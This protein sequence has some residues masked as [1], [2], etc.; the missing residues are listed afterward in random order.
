MWCAVCI[1]FHCSVP[2]GTDSKDRDIFYFPMFYNDPRLY[3][4]SKNKRGRPFRLRVLCDTVEG[5]EGQYAMF[6]KSR[7]KADKEIFAS[8]EEVMQHYR[9]QR[10]RLAKEAEK[11]KKL[12]AMAQL[13]RRL[14]GR[15]RRKRIEEER[16]ASTQ[17]SAAVG[18]ASGAPHLSTPQLSKCVSATVVD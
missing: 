15:L 7:R 4:M 16:E 1:C 9:D 14:S 17:G 8:L 12:E 2:V 18:A 5:L 11:K 10:E 13:P 6:K 3:A